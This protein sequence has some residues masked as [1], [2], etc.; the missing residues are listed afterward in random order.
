MHKHPI[1]FTL[2]LDKETWS[3][4]DKIS[5]HWRCSRAEALRRMTAAAYA[6]LFTDAPKC[7]DGSNCSV[8]HLHQ[9]PKAI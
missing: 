8:P 5:T 9:K 7:A 6:H 1:I 2:R 4:L 3:E